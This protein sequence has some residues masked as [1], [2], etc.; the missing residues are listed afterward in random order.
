MGWGMGCDRKVCDKP[1]DCSNDWTSNYLANQE[2]RLM[3]EQLTIFDE[4]QE[5]EKIAAAIKES[6]PDICPTTP[7]ATEEK[8]QRL[9]SAVRYLS[10]TSEFSA[11]L[12]RL[13]QLL[14]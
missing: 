3:G 9:A 5:L 4:F 6:W 10:K 11:K 2:V 7:V 12:D 8:A 1:M 13:D 14:K